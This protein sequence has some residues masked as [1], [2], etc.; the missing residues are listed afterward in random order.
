LDPRVTLSTLFNSGDFDGSAQRL[1]ANLTKPIAWFL[2]GSKDVGQWLVR[3]LSTQLCYISIDN[4]QG[5]RDFTTVGNTVPALKST[6]N[7]GHIGTFY[8]KYGGRMGKAA[9][10]FFTWQMKGNQTG[11]AEFCNPSPS[12]VLGGLGF[13]TVTKNRMC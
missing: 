11:K 1:I 2:G 4:I 12:S 6:A 9:V 3:T 13:N 5:D 10:A 8:Q 7:L